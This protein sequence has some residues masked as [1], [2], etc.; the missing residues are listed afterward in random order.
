LHPGSFGS[1]L[2]WNTA[3][4]G[5][6][7]DTFSGMQT[8]RRILSL[9][10]EGLPSAPHVP[11]MCPHGLFAGFVAFFRMVKALVLVDMLSLQHQQAPSL[12]FVGGTVD[13]GAGTEA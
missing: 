9:L 8:D 6:N 13:G 10:Q 2:V 5:K 7:S 11:F 3:F 12:A 1:F 4:S